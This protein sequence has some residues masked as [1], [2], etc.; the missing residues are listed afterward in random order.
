M[1]ILHA[2]NPDTLAAHWL[3][4]LFDFFSSYAPLCQFLVLAG[5]SFWCYYF[6]R[7]YVTSLGKIRWPNIQVDT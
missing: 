5:S 1:T 4:E 6:L 3:E 7:I 2:R